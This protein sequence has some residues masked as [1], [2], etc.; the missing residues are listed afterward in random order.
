MVKREESGSLD[1]GTTGRVF[2][3]FLNRIFAKELLTS[4]RDIYSSELL[5]PEKYSG[6]GGGLNFFYIDAIYSTGERY[7]YFA[8]RGEPSFLESYTYTHNLY[9][10]FTVYK[11]L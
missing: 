6:R 3:E 9:A 2:N 8:E 7:L 4:S 10:S 5:Q 11:S 1:S